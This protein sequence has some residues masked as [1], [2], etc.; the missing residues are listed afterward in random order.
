MRIGVL[1]HRVQFSNLI[2]AS[3]VVNRERTFVLTVAVVLPGAL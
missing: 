1:E 2:R 3:S